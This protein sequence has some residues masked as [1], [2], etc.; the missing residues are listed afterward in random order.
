MQTIDF[1]EEK[2]SEPIT[3]SDRIFQLDIFR[4]F[5]I[6]GIFM[7]NIL[8]MN[9]A[10]EFRVEWEGW[11]ADSF[12]KGILFILETF[13]YSKFFPIFSFLFGIGV[14]LQIENFKKKDISQ[15][16]FFFRRFSALFVFGVAHVLFIWSGDI[17]H[18]YA[19]IGFVLL[20]ISP[21]K[22][23]YTFLFALA[24]FF[25]PY[26]DDIYTWMITSLEVDP[27]YHIQHM[28]RYEMIDLKRGGSYLSG[29]DLRL[30]E[31]GYMT[32]FIASTFAPVAA[33]M[34]LIGMFVV[35]KGFIGRLSEFAWN[36]RL[37]FSL[38]VIFAIGFKYV[39]VY[40]IV[41]NVEM[42]FGGLLSF[43]LW[44]FYYV[45]EVTIALF[46]LW[47]LTLLLRFEFWKKFLA[48]LKY[49]G[50]MA[51]TN[52]IFQ[53]VV[54]Y[55]I[56]RTFGYYERFSPSECVLIVMIVFAIQIPLSW[57]W[58]HYFKYGPL[59]WLWRCIS[60]WKILPIGKISQKT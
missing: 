36:I 42:E 33:S 53:S 52:Y 46:Y 54:G 1:S 51:F 45:G 6:F 35:K 24:I 9:C 60:Y 40:L 13:F 38:F 48:P 28:T 18:I 31:Y 5:A 26:F 32:P 29:I 14:A 16:L 30:K 3:N 27:P 2:S 20:L 7:V 21:L 55:L 57:L 56:M 49:V 47:I 17:L 37:K 15:G 19:V 39:I 10:F 34:A 25:F 50:R 58:L 11:Y 23:I 8:V 59:E 41:P 22:P 44:S 43:F 12:N 4:G